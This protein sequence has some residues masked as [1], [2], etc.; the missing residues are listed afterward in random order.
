MTRGRRAAQPPRGWSPPQSLDVTALTYAATVDDGDEPYVVDGSDW[1]APQQLVVDLLLG[2]QRLVETEGRWRQRTTVQHNA[3]RAEAFARWVATWDDP[4][5]SQFAQ[6]QSVTDLTAGMWSAYALSLGT[7]PQARRNQIQLALM[8]KATGRLTDE[9]AR[10]VLARKGKVESSKVDHYTLEEFRAIVVAAKRVVRSAH[11]RIAGNYAA[12][13]SAEQYR[14]NLTRESILFEMLTTTYPRSKPKARVLGTVSNL[15]WRNNARD[16]MESGVKILKDPARLLLFPD[17]QEAF[18]AMVLLAALRG[19]NLSQVETMRIPDRTV[20]SHGK[21]A[22]VATDKPRRGPRR[23]FSLEVFGDSGDD[24]D[25]R[26]L[27]RIEEMTDPLRHHLHLVGTDSDLLI[28]HMTRGKVS[29]RVPGS[30]SRQGMTW[31]DGLPTISFPRLK[32]T[33]ETRHLREAVQNT[34]STHISVYVQRDPERIAEYQDLAAAGIARAMERALAEVRLTIVKGD[35]PKLADAVDS[36]FA[37]CVDPDHEPRTGLPC[38]DGFLGC[39]SCPN[40]IATD[41]H[42]P[43]MRYTLNLLEEARA[44][45]PDSQWSHRFARAHAQLTYVVSTAPATPHHKRVTRAQ[46][47]LIRAALGLPERKP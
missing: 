21:L 26:W 32:R 2:I 29:N 12:A 15:T 8:L 1:G 45:T 39:L 44:A 25:G 28:L 3:Y 38:Q 40:A 43:L 20:D 37:S 27:R 22:Q 18:A 23:R 4:N 42:I 41:R 47:D 31:L 30:T 17:Q 11:E 5:V 10:R 46:Q 24:T 16:R 13:L 9:A 19:L 34:E 35:S 36:A 33:F 6:P 14:G 7:G